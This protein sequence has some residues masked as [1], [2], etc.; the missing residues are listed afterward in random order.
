MKIKPPQTTTN[1]EDNAQFRRYSSQTLDLIITEM[2]GR[3]VFGENIRGQILTVTFSAS[4]VDVTIPHQLAR[5]PD[6]YFQI[7]SSA[8]TNLY[9]GTMANDSQN[10]YL[11]ASSAGT[12]RLFLF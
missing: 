11:R 10:A 4:N 3:L 5:I 1:I 12:V 2:N 7:G 9:D 8:A 6:G